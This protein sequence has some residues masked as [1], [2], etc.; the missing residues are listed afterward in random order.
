MKLRPYIKWVMIVVVLALVG[1]FLGVPAYET[2]VLIIRHEEVRIQAGDV[3][4][5]ATIS[6]PTIQWLQKQRVLRQ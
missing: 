4:L 1:I 3:E 6:T 2:G 5:A